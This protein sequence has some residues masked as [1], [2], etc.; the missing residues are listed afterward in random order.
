MC[1][2]ENILEVKII[3]LSLIVY[4][5]GVN[6][7]L[8]SKYLNSFYF[9][10]KKEIKKNIKLIKK[11]PVENA[12]KGWGS[13]LA[14]HPEEKEKKLPRNLYNPIRSYHPDEYAII[15]ILS[16]IEPQKFN[17]N[18]HV[19]SIGGV[20]LYFVGFLLFLLAKLNFISLTKDIIFYFFH[21]EEIAKFYIVGRIVT[22]IYGVGVILL[23][24]SLCKKVFKKDMT[25]NFLSS[26]L[27]LFA[28][29]I[30]L[31][32]HYMY[33]DIPG[34]FWIMACLFITSSC[35]EKFSFKK[36]LLA[37]IFSG[38][39]C[40][41]KITFFVSLI[42]PVLGIILILKNFK[43]I[44]KSICLILIGFFV[45]F[46]ITNPYFFLTFPAPLAELKQHTGLS[47]NGKFYFLSLK[48]GLG[49]PLL[50]FALTGTILNLSFIKERENI[51]KK[52]LFLFFL[53][54]IFFFIFISMFSKNFARYILPIIPAF[55]ILGVDGWFLIL[56]KT[57]KFFKFLIMSFIIFVSFF[58]FIYGMSY[59][60]LFV[61]KN[62][63]T[64]AGEWIKQNIKV[65]ETIGVTEVPWQFQMPP[66]N[67][68]SYK[69]VV[70]GYDIKNIEKQL[71]RYFILSSFQSEI[72]PYPLKLERRKIEFWRDFKS[73]KLYK[74]VKIFKKF[75]S[76]AKFKFKQKTIPEDLIYLNPTIIVYK[77]ETNE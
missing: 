29:L 23:S 5:V 13:Y 40:G 34:L 49:V 39:A 22:A 59:E 20:Y 37:G 11:Y 26:F 21:P 7:G 38:L 69:T 14:L 36:V 71:P 8:P 75:P 18:P 16:S 55:V 67:Y 47:F 51:E 10:N 52:I 3:L 42:I 72:S 53:W 63:R 60:M 19:Y 50:I 65:A 41:T 44:F 46:F 66:F 9:R 77:K 62:T 12:W 70:T 61:Q 30:I 54:T 24:Y 25:K 64:E 32:S 31:N 76:F 28:P 17:F 48:Y 43:N 27:I 2:R 58:T 74:P 33:V 6:W 15:K 56:N 73:L 4:L 45:S 68:N 35:I 57:R 1:K